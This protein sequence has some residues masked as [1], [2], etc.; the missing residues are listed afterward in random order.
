MGAGALPDPVFCIVV[1]IRDV[2]N[3]IVPVLV[4]KFL[5]VGCPGPWT[6]TGRRRQR[7]RGREIL[8]SDVYSQIAS[9]AAEDSVDGAAGRAG[10]NTHRM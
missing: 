8:I 3:P 6:R 4:F 10:T 5:K 2:C 7:S 9:A 1:L